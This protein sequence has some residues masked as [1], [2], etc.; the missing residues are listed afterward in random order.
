MQYCHEIGRL[1]DLKYPECLHGKV[2]I[3]MGD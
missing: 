3:I 1:Q 2:E